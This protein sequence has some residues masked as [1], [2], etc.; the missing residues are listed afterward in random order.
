MTFVLC[1]FFFVGQCLS[2]VT[3]CVGA[4]DSTPCDSDNNPCTVERCISSVCVLFASSCDLLYANDFETPNS[5]TLQ[6]TCGGS[7]DLRP[8]NTLYGPCASLP[9][10]TACVSNPSL[11]GG[12]RG[13]AAPA[14]FKQTNTVEGVLYNIPP[15]ACLQGYVQVPAGRGGNYGIGMLSVI[16]NDILSLTFNTLGRSSINIF[17]D[18]AS[19]DSCGCGVSSNVGLIAPRYRLV[20]V[21]D[22]TGN[23]PI[24]SYSGSPSI[25]DQAFATGIS[26]A[27]ISAISWSAQ[28]IYLS[29]QGKSQVTLIWDLIDAPYSVF[30]NLFI[31]SNDCPPCGVGS[32]CN[33]ATAKCQ[34]LPPVLLTLAE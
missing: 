15:N 21:D 22:P 1:V 9:A 31:V 16:Q 11:N 34:L 2:T 17:F 29:T 30:D 6:I 32:Y 24:E 7:L 33:T 8:I 27:N 23:F 13:L 26:P 28:S 19:L 10:Q 25:L 5:G 18:M 12:A 20:L 14:S 3:T 4:P